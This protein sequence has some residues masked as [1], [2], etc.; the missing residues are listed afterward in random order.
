[1][2]P[3]SARTGQHDGGKYATIPIE[4]RRAIA[5]ACIS[6]WLE[7]SLRYTREEYA[8]RRWF[9][10]TEARR[11]Y[12]RDLAINFAAIGVRPEL[13][14]GICDFGERLFPNYDWSLYRL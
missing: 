4:L 6:Q 12:I 3:A 9:T 8:A 5:E 7:H 2:R 10:F 14:N 11:N 13:V 1:M